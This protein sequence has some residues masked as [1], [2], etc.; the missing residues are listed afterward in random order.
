[1]RAKSYQLLGLINR[2]T[3]QLSPVSPNLLAYSSWKISSLQSL[4][5]HLTYTFISLN[6]KAILP[7]TN[8]N[9]NQKKIMRCST[10]GT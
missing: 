2:K 7:L 10:M 8:K 1:M 5:L 9:D 3:G 6:Y 4:W